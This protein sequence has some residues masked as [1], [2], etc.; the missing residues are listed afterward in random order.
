MVDPHEGIIL[1]GC[2]WIIK[3]KISSDGQILTYKA[4]LVAKGYRQRQAIDY[5]KTFSPIAMLKS[6]RM[7]L[8][9]IAYY[10]YETWQMNIKMDFLNRFL[11]EEIYME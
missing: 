10:D 1:I 2:K 3:R 6:I 11:E 5:D 7:M 9:I 8:A 4:W